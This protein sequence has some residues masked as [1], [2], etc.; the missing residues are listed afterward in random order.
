M[1]VR[2]KLFILALLVFALSACMHNST[3]GEVVSKSDGKH[4]TLL[5]GM[6]RFTIQTT[7]A[8]YDAVAIGVRYSFVADS[9][10]N[11]YRIFNEVHAVK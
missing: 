4:V 3:E 1:N 2:V 7:P 6:R 5:D 10:D 9:L 11:A 8:V